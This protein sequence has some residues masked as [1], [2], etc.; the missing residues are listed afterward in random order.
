MRRV[1]AALTLPLPGTRV[2]EGAERP[3]STG[4]ELFTTTHTDGNWA[5]RL[6]RP[7]AAPTDRTEEQ[8]SYASV[9][10]GREALRENV[11]A[12]RRNV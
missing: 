2:A 10:M 5:F 8:S 6:L 7:L 11:S 12:R 3:H 1:D 9:I 4:G